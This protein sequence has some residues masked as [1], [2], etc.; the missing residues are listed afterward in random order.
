MDMKEAAAMTEASGLPDNQGGLEQTSSPR[1]GSGEQRGAANPR[2]GSPSLDSA[3]RWADRLR[4]VA[5]K[6]P[7][8]SL[9]V[10]FLAGVWIARRR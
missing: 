10:A 9:F 6:A 5:M 3:S 8:R 2:P 1:S 4:E 7:L